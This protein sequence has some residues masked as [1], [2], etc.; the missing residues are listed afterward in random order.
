VGANL[1][2][3][4]HAEFADGST[5]VMATRIPRSGSIGLVWRLK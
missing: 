5:G 1:L 3:P 2:A 4:D